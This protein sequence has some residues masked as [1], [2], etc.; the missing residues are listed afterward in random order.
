MYGIISSLLHSIYNVKFTECKLK[1]HISTS[2]HEVVVYDLEEELNISMSNPP[3][4][5]A[6]LDFT[7]ETAASVS[8]SKVC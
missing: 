3:E 6:Y 2:G 1:L 8:A 4:E 7:T 5:T